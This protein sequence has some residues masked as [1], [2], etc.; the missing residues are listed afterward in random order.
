MTAYRACAFALGV[1]VVLAAQVPPAD[2]RLTPADVEKVTGFPV[3][4][5]APGSKPGAGPGLNFVGP[6][7]K[8]V[9][10]VN[11]GTA[12]LYER[13]KAQTSPIALYHQAI[14]GLGDDA[15]ESP[16]GKVQ[17]MLYM[18]KGNQA[19][20]LTAYLDVRA[21]PR[22]TMDQLKQIAQVVLPRL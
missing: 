5:I 3:R 18:R 11:F 22:L 10:M 21:G 17:Y 20:S 8:L 12:A 6:D 2:K 9:L 13:A 14:P 19:I 1:G 15:F 7:D 4:Q 16:S